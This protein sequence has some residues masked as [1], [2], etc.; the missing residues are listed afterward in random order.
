MTVVF[1]PSLFEDWNNQ[2]NDGLFRLRYRLRGREEVYPYIAHIDLNDSMA[3]HL[4]FSV[5]DRNRF[6]RLLTVLADT[7]VEAV[8]FDILFPEHSFPENDRVLVEATEYSGMAYYPVVLQPEEYRRLFNP[9]PQELEEHV[10]AETLWHPRVVR[11]GEPHY[12]ETAIANF[13]EL[14]LLAR[15]IGH[16]NSDPDRDGVHRRFPLL[17]RYRDGFFPSLTFRMAC[18]YLEVDFRD[19]EV[20]F[21]DY[22][23][24][25]GARFP[26]GNERDIRIPIDRQGRMI[27]N[28][29][30]P[31]SD[32]FTHYSFEKLL[33]AEMDEDLFDALADEME[34]LLVVIS[35]VTTKTNDQGPIPFER[36][37]PLSGLHSNIL[38]T[39]LTENFLHTPRLSLTLL[40]NLFLAALLW[41]FAR[42]TRALSFSLFSILVYVLFLL[43]TAWLFIDRQRLADLIPC[44][45][46][47]FLSLI[48]V[49][50][51]RFFMAER[52]KIL[53]RLRFERY[54]APELMSKILKSPEKLMAV[55]KK[56][57]TI[58]FS[59][60]AGFTSW[61]TT[62]SPEQ[63]LVTLNEYFDE[64]TGIIFDYGGTVDKF[65]GD[66]LMS[67]FGDPIDQPDHALRAVS[68]AIEMQRKVRELRNA[69]EL[70][71][72]LAIKIRIGI[73]TGEVV[74]GDMGSKRIVDYTVIGANVNLSQ[75]LESIA[76]VGGIL[77]SEPVFEQV[78]GAVRADYIGKI[79]A[80]G[81]DQEFGAYEVEVPL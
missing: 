45:A 1:L 51:Y 29:A 43:F 21:G 58:M 79:T 47:I 30:G 41:I 61:C 38:N 35:D 74:V 9:S 32:S 71:G 67:F 66:G 53:M 3:R 56:V 77:I 68:A 7:Y 27:I 49:N 54:F 69:W 16:I 65:I 37:Y 2:I 57:V 11:E 20:S 39:I 23:L 60:I 22:I 64:M 10:L 72:R 12:A 59:D 34:G 76:P 42:Y 13:P 55:E 17:Y 6:G 24:L 81:I 31:W 19:V 33:K 52:E 14:V 80:K 78:G 40:L 63:V 75:R 26:N 5:W 25:P 28:Y 46:G 48:A 4:Q 15:G 73:N 62:Q 36:I 8:A 50:I 44:S 70:Q 18:D